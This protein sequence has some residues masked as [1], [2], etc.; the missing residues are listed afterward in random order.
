MPL[1][2]IKMAT[3]LTEHVPGITIPAAIMARLEKGGLEAGLEIA[4]EQYE[5]LRTFAA[6]VHIMPMNHIDV[7]QKIVD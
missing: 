7:V 2:G 1:R 4:Q 5:E 6:G 3:Y